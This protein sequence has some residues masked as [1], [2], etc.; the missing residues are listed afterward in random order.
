MY[1]FTT[2]FFWL[3]ISVISVCSFVPSVGSSSTFTVRHYGGDVVY[4]IYSLL[5]ANA[6]TIADDIIAT[7]NSKV[8]LFLCVC[9]YVCLHVCIHE[10]M[11]VCMN[12]VMN[13]YI[14]G[15]QCSPHRIV[16]SVLWLICLLWS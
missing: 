8:S 12:G 16:H 9:V 7:F 5:N 6:D 1:S 3:L 2:N 13:V 11:C 15:T 4:D 14:H 10:C